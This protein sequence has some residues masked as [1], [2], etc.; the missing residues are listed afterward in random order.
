MKHEGIGISVASINICP[1]NLNLVPTSYL[2]LTATVAQAR[3]ANCVEI[4]LALKQRI[5]RISK[6]MAQNPLLGE[7][8]S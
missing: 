8:A 4:V 2:G 5:E 6:K 7:L 3:K 1:Y